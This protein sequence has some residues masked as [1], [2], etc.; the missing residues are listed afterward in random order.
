MTFWPKIQNSYVKL[1]ELI[2]LRYSVVQIIRII[3]I[4]QNSD[5]N[6]KSI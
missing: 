2:V 1:I 6:P 5:F 3:N 4:L